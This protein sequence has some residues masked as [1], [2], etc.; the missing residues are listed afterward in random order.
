[1]E[2]SQKHKISRLFDSVKR[3]GWLTGFFK[4]FHFYLQAL[5]KRC[6]VNTLKILWFRM[7]MDFLMTCLDHD[8]IKMLTEIKASFNHNKTSG[9]V[10]AGLK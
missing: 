9:R 8:N 4:F 10:F 1:V 5:G 6:L 3:E 7:S 2:F